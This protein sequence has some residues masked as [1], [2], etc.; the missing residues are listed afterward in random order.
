LIK[1]TRT[2]WKN[3]ISSRRAIAAPVVPA[4]ACAL[5]SFAT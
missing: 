5:V 3:A 1:D 2:A 4:R